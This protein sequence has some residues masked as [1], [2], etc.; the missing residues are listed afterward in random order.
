MR[1]MILFAALVQSVWA[2]AQPTFPVNGAREKEVVHTAITHAILHVNDIEVLNDATLLFYKGRIVNVGSNI[3]LPSGTV[4]L[5]YKNKHIYPSFVD[6]YSNY[7]QPAVE[8]AQWSPFPNPDRNRKG[9]YG[10][11]DAIHADYAASYHFNYDEAAANDLIKAGVGAVVTHRKDGIVRGSGALVALDDNENMALLQSNVSGH[12]S[13]EKGSSKQEYP[14]SLMGS[15]ALLRQT[16]FDAEWY[17]N[18]GIQQERNLSLES[19]LQLQQFP[20]FFET[21]DKWNVMRADN[22][23]DEM[24]VQYIFKGSGNEY[25]RIQEISA[26]KGSFIPDCAFVMELTKGAGTTFDLDVLDDWVNV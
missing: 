17:K 23:G 15:I 16:Y 25:Q 4:I 8:Q 5:D 22:I 7:G 10:W 24:K 1:K 6:L 11:N 2:Y 12:Y 21:D 26:T 14:S 19:F 13:F 9:A 18:Q 3:A 20:S